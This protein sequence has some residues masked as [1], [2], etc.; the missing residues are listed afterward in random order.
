MT[1]E[2]Q[3]RMMWRVLL[4]GALGSSLWGG[5][6][7]AQTIEVVPLDDGL[8]LN[9]DGQPVISLEQVPLEENADL[10]LDPITAEEMGLG[11]DIVLSDEQFQTF[12]Q[13]TQ[14]AMAEGGRLRVLDK[15]TGRTSDLDLDP[16]QS[17][18]SGRLTVTMHECRFPAEDPTSEA[19]ARL[20]IADEQGADLFTGWM[21]ASSPALMALDHP[22]YDVWVLGCRVRAATPEVAAGIR[23]PRPKPRPVR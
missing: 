6:L 7:V 23:S 11:P 5:M 18:V 9:Q 17:T 20:S 22:R 16:E 2:A 3:R 10:G 12:E 1:F 14:I 15:M 8:S 4:C 19:Y 13:D 21:V